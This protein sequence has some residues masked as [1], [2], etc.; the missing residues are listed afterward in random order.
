MKKEINVILGQRIKELRKSKGYTRESFAETVSISPR[1]L[2]DVESG[3]AGV[4][5]S[6][7]KTIALLLDTSADYLIG[8]SNI[9]NEDLSKQSAIIKINNMDGKYLGYVNTILDCIDDITKA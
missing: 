5:I 2:A 7:L 6:T 1:F 4:S 9:D 3:N 8:I